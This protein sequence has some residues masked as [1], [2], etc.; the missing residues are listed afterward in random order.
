MLL[1]VWEQIRRT[2]YNPTN[3]GRLKLMNRIEKNVFIVIVLRT[4]SKQRL[5]YVLYVVSILFL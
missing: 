3:T 4:I 1:L 2:K 5:V